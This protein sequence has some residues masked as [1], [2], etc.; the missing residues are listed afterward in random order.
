MR[1]HSC[2]CFWELDRIGVTSAP[3]DPQRIARAMPYVSTGP[4][5]AHEDPRDPIAS[6]FVPITNYPRPRI[7][8]VHCAGFGSQGLPFDDLASG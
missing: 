8:G 2:L 7:S 5:D 4:H 3:G 1:E 6:V